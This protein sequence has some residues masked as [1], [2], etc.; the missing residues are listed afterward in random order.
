MLALK[1]ITANTPTQ[2]LLPSKAIPFAIAMMAPNRYTKKINTNWVGRDRENRVHIKWKA[3]EKPSPLRFI[4]I[5]TKLII[6]AK[7]GR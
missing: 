2:N 6:L 5:D 1:G 3:S 4:S 7:M